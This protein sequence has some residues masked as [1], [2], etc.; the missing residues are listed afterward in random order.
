MLLVINR[1]A[2]GS[3]RCRERRGVISQKETQFYSKA[4]QIPWTLNQHFRNNRV[5]LKTHTGKD[6]HYPLSAAAKYD[7]WHA[8]YAAEFDLRVR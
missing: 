4:Q 5:R 7:E 8:Q 2:P 3:Y 6:K 1:R